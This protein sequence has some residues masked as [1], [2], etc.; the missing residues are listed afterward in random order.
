MSRVTCQGGVAPNEILASAEGLEALV[1]QG[2]EPEP[3]PP[4]AVTERI[5]PD[6]A[7]WRG[8]VAMRS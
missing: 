7:K 6:I 4:R 5:R 2:L 1:A 8:V 3:G